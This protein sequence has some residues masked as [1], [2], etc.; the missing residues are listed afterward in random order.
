MAQ[1]TTYLAAHPDL[2]I[3]GRCYSHHSRASSKPTLGEV[4][5]FQKQVG[6]FTTLDDKET[7]NVANDNDDDDNNDRDTLARDAEFEI[8]LW[9]KRASKVSYHH[10]IVIWSNSKNE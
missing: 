7:Q 10:H 2:K 6:G 5:A 4:K 8:H 1:I 9:L 3:F